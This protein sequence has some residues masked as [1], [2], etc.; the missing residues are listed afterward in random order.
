[1]LSPSCAPFIV[2]AALVL[3]Y[4]LNYPVFDS[5]D[6]LRIRVG[7]PWPATGED[8]SLCGEEEDG[9][10]C[11]R[12]HDFPY[13]VP[14]FCFAPRIE[15]L[16][17]FYN[18]SLLPLYNDTLYPVASVPLALQ[19]NSSTGLV[20]DLIHLHK[21]QFE[22]YLAL[23]IRCNAPDWHMGY[24]LKRPLRY[25]QYASS[26]V[27]FG[28]VDAQSRFY[29]QGGYQS[30]PTNSMSRRSSSGYSKPFVCA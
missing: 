21:Q 23:T 24:L 1:M 27:D 17:P 14:P 26:F 30:R 4:C 10:H 16:L 5:V 13:A 8:F 12:L 22:V 20:V 25:R 15:S 3:G 2:W 18:E 9:L 7:V 6:E 28:K 11:V 19:L 29:W